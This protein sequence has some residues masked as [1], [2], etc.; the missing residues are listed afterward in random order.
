MYK[1]SKLVK[2]NFFRDEALAFYWIFFRQRADFNMILKA[3]E[4]RDEEE[5]EQYPKELPKPL[6]NSDEGAIIGDILAEFD[7]LAW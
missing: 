2:E 4:D 5:E 1:Y 6:I 7:K 3:F